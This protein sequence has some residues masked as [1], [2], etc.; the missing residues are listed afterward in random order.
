[1]TAPETLTTTQG[2]Q[3]AYHKTEGDGPCVVF[4]GG[5][6][7]DM[8][9]TKAVWLEDWCRD[10]GRAYLR[11]DYSGHG[12]SSGRFDEGCIGHNHWP[13][14]GPLRPYVSRFSLFLFASCS[15]RCRGGSGTAGTVTIEGH[16]S[17]MCLR[18]GVRNF[19][20]M[21]KPTQ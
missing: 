16:P 10:R 5:F 4:L 7:S 2:R 3:I 6:K 17:L 12:V 13:L 9:G 19:G 8:A 1:M 20:S 15:R 14:K 18:R 21:H 11:F